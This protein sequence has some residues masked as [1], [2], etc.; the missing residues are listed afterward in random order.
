MKFNNLDICVQVKCISYCSSNFSPPFRPWKNCKI[1][2]ITEEEGL[3]NVK[4]N[5]HE[6]DDI[7]DESKLNYL[8][9]NVYIGIVLHAEGENGTTTSLTMKGK[10]IIGIFT[11]N[12]KINNDKIIT[13]YHDI[14]E[15]PYNDLNNNYELCA[16][17]R[18]F[19][20]SHI[21]LSSLNYSNKLQYIAIF[22]D[23]IFFVLPFLKLVLKRKFLIM[24]FL[25]NQNGEKDDGKSNGQYDQIKKQ[26]EQFHISSKCIEE[27]V[28][29]L[30]LDMNI[31]EHV[32]N[33][34][35]GLGIKTIFVFPNG[36]SNINV[37][38]RSIFTISALNA[39]IIFTSNFDYLNPH[40]CKLLYEKGISVHFFN[41][42]NYIKYDYF[43]MTDSFNYV[44]L[45]ILNKDI[46]IP[47]VPRTT[48]SFSNIEEILSSG[49]PP[50]GSSYNIYVNKNID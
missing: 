28:S 12:C 34:T 15:Y 1:V 23:Q 10:S 36:N 24:I 47:S 32:Y 30:N 19:Y 7:K 40:E 27:R 31:Q 3:A 42:N 14:I 26:L 50:G 35:N 18:S 5:G 9:G 38:K 22:A 6:K 29:I 21:C 49:P 8:I 46:D 43:K 41:L 13:P 48:K 20:E 25:S 11:L 17:L 37:L 4:V 33:V 39:R 44:L 45:S 2:N 16:V